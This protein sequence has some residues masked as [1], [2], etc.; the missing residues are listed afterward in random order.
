MIDVSYEWFVD[1]MLVKPVEGDK[2]NV[3]CLIIWRCVGTHGETTGTQSGEV[4]IKY[5]GVGDF[6]PYEELTKDIVFNWCWST[7]VNKEDIETLVM[8]EI[9]EKISPKIIALPMPW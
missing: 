9:S 1:Q 2:K 7:V 6:V 3:V 5:D 4:E 8:E